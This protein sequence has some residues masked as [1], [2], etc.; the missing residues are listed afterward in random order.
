MLINKIKVKG[1]TMNLRV[2]LLCL[3]IVPSIASAEIY[4]WKDNDGN[5]RYSDVPPLSNVKKEALIG[6]KIP[7]PTG[8]APLTAVE[9]DATS[10]ANR[11]KMID[12]EKAAGGKGIIP[13]Q[14]MSKDQAAAKRAKDAEAKKNADEMAKQKQANCLAAK[15]NVKTYTDGG[16]LARTN[17]NGERENLS[18]ADIKKGII[19][20]QAEIDK[21]C[22]Q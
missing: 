2:F 14:P 1:L 13:E 8:L 19:D 4:K 5:Y 21:Y 20:S 22:D 18:D 15:S 12:K 9:G 10:A 17:A 16:R 3:V 7:K 11:Q 6:K